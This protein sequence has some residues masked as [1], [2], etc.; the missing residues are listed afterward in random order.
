MQK[1]V[2]ICM[3]QNGYLLEKVAICTYFEA[4]CYKIECVLLQNRMR[5]A[6]KWSAFCCK[7]QGIL[8]LNAVQFA[9]KCETI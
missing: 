6:A 7:T 8:V 9:A 3:R 1:G 4:I 5:F 2:S